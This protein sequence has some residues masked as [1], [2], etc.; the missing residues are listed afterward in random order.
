MP[1]Y[2]PKKTVLHPDGTTEDI[3]RIEMS[4]EQEEVAFKFLIH[5][6]KATSGEDD[7]RLEYL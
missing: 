3:G 7:P 6:I 5:I 2:L 4:P 1:F